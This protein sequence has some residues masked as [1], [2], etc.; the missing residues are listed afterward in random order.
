MLTV[1]KTK[2]GDMWDNIAKEIYG[3]ESYVSFL[4][5]N[6]QKYLDYFLFPDGVELRIEELPQETSTLPEWRS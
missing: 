2:S 4:M 3:S 5:L 1:Y 6:N